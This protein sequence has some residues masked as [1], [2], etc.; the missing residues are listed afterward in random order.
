MK[1]DAIIVGARCSGA[2]TAMLLARKGHRVLL[3]DRA[4]F[5]SDIPHGHF[6]HQQGPMRL[7]KWGLLDAITSSN[8]PRTESISVDLGDFPLESSGIQVDG[9]AFG[10]GPRRK[11]LDQVLIDE[12]VRAGVELREGVA[13]E[14][15]LS[16]GDR[17]TGIRAR[18][19]SGEVF[20]EWATMTIGADGRGSRLARTVCAP[21]Y[22]ATP[23]LMCYSFSYWSGVP[24]RRL[25][26]VLRP[27]RVFFAFPTNDDLYAVFSGAPISE[28]ARMSTN[29][30]RHFEESLALAPSFAQLLRSG[31]REERFSGAG[32]LPNFF[33]KPFGTGW[34]LVGD[35]GHHK[36]PYMA[37]GLNDAFRDAE[38]LSDALD[39]AFSGRSSFDAALGEYER[40]RNDAAAGA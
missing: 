31:R 24:E 5:P 28:L 36:D 39:E 8:C 21:V 27:Y 22:D 15:F 32:D 12:A 29:P 13:V 1:Y 16:D 17:I 23:T 26:I 30:E 3:V 14:S 20:N 2:T 19:R 37:L 9:V 33:R 18:G 4:R 40:R 35:A 11:V 10:Y 6:I 25:R 34:A 38:F 7:K